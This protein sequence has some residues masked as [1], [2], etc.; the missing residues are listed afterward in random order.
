MTKKSFTPYLAL[1][2]RNSVVFLSW[3]CIS[4][5]STSVTKL[6]QNRNHQNHF[7]KLTCHCD[8]IV[9][10]LELCLYW[11]KFCFSLVSFSLVYCRTTGH[12]PASLGQSLL[13][14][15]LSL[16]VSYLS[17]S[18]PCSLPSVFYFISRSPSNLLFSISPSF[19]HSVFLSPL[20]L[21]C[22]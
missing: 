1:I 22:L 7:G 20:L 17:T 6:F 8:D 12:T 15:S 21:L 2:S 5:S 3:H 18:L 16:S 11:S 10:M 9:I 14:L 19:S 4:C 13:S